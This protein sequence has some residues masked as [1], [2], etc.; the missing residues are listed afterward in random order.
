MT[1]SVVFTPEAQEQLVA[2]YRY[3]A[4]AASP[5]IAERYVSAI[6]TPSLTYQKKYLSKSTYCIAKKFI[7][8]QHTR[9]FGI[10][11]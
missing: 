10:S 3:I 2:L 5:E 8:A 7:M 11:R 6:V 9:N 4:T 1:Y